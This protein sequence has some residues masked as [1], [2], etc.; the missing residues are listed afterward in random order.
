MMMIRL[1]R[2]D[3]FVLVIVHVVIDYKDETESEKG[4]IKYRVFTISLPILKIY[5]IYIKLRLVNS[6]FYT[7]SLL[8]MIMFFVIVFLFL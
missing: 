8:I 5:R 7:S 2:I 1:I 3:L 4:C 6:I